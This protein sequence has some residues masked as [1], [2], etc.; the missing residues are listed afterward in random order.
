M[1]ELAVLG[2]VM[3][4]GVAMA[5]A[6][7]AAQFCGSATC[8]CGSAMC[9]CGQVCTF[10]G[11]NPCQPAQVGYCARDGQ[12][13]ATCGSFVCRG[14]YCQP[15]DGGTSGA[16]GGAAGVGGGTAGTGGGA[17]G[18]GGGAASAGGC[19]CTSAGVLPLFGLLCGLA[20]YRRRHS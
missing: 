19:G 9:T 14:N 12:C 8:P 16:G 6:G 7:L 3:F 15:S 11:L 5:E 13:A 10:G 18:T 1:K 17:S 4:G 20:L 2:L